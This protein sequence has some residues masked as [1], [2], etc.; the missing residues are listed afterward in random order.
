MHR[1]IQQL[2]PKSDHHFALSQEN[3]CFSVLLRPWEGV[4]ER[5]SRTQ[6]HLGS[7]H[8]AVDRI[9]NPSYSQRLGG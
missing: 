8:G 2:E 7:M 5:I 6:V 3:Q 4:S 1:T 9:N